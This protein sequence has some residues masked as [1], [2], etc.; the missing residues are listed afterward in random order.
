MD[1]TDERVCVSAQIQV[2]NFKFV[3]KLFYTFIQL[4]R[5]NQN[6]RLSLLSNGTLWNVTLDRHALDSWTLIERFV[7]SSC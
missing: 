5:N 6:D 4:T 2:K 1:T 3:R 7:I